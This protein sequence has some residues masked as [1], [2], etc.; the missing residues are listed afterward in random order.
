MLFEN[1]RQLVGA[2]VKPRHADPR[3]GDVKDSQADISKARRI[4]GYQPIVSFE[5][6]LERTVAWYRS[7]QLSVA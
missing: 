4:L 6:G 7:S 3:A 2:E 5:D 1:V